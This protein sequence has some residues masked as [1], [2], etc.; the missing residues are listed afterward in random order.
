MIVG[1]PEQKEKGL[2]LLI[3]NHDL[4]KIK[5]YFRV[6][7]L[8]DLQESKVNQ[9]IQENQVSQIIKDCINL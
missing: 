9:E 8:R 6:K 1:S 5:I 3:K 4:I 2:A 7:V